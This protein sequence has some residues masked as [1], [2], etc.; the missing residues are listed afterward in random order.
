MS[1]SAVVPAAVALLRE[2]Y[3]GTLRRK[4]P[5]SRFKDPRQMYEW[6]VHGPGAR[7]LVAD[8]A[9]LLIEKA[10]QARLILESLKGRRRTS[11]AVLGLAKEKRRSFPFPASAADGLANLESTLC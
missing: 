8:L 6:A 9:P 3:G 11:D 10:A 5:D 2:V 4:P 1:V 7:R